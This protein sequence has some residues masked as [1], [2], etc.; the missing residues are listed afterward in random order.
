MTN[1]IFIEHIGTR[2]E[3]KTIIQEAIGDYFGDAKPKQEKYLSRA[4]VKKRLGICYPT[5]DKALDKG[6]LIGYRIGGRIL[7]KESELNLSKFARRH[8]KNRK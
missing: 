5:L 2:E 7:M 4:E 8:Y 3:L 6:E 1:S